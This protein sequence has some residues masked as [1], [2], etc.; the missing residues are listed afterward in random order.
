MWGHYRFHEP[1]VSQRRFPQK[2][3]N[4]VRLIAIAAFLVPELGQRKTEHHL[5]QA[6]GVALLSL[7]VAAPENTAYGLNQA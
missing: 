3:G 2:A 4:A 7:P 1:L 5:P 6:S